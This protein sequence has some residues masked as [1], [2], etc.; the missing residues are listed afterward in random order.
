MLVLLRYLDLSK[1]MPNQSEIKNKKNKKTTIRR[2]W[3][4]AV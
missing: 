4:L 2:G 1:V 3:D